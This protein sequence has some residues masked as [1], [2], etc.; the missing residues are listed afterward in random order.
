[1]YDI[2]PLQCHGYG[3]LWVKVGGFNMYVNGRAILVQ[4]TISVRIGSD[5]KVHTYFKNGPF[6]YVL[7]YQLRLH[8]TSLFV[9]G[10]P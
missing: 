3:N 5:P 1:M 4:I 9:V 10:F 6:Q 7:L 8:V 2:L